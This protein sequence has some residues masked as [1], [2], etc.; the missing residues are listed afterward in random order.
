MIPY[1]IYI[2]AIIA[3]LVTSSLAL[4]DVYTQDTYRWLAIIGWSLLAGGN[5]I[6]LLQ[7]MA[8]RSKI[9]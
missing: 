4:L 9:P 2:T 1:I 5:L 6:F 8:E 3:A 7:H